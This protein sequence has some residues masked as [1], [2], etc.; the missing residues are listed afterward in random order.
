MKSLTL[1]RDMNSQLKRNA[2]RAWE[3]VYRRMKEMEDREKEG[4]DRER[5]ADRN[6]PAEDGQ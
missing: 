5:T 6:E 4:A 3:Q 1:D 2:D